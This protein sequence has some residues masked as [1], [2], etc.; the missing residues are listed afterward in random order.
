MPK[1]PINLFDVKDSRVVDPATYAIRFKS[2][3]QETS[4]AGNEMTLFILEATEPGLEGVVFYDRV[5]HT[6]EAGWK[7]KQMYEATGVHFDASGFDTD[8]LIHA[9]CKVTVDK[10][11]YE[12]KEKNTVEAYLKM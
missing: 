2:Q 3:K 9:E 1:V 5:V 6:P 4:K 10:E 7:W 11:V 12:G 8:D